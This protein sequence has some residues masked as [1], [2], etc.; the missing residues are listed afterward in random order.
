MGSA[1][2]QAAAAPNQDPPPKTFV[3]STPEAN[4]LASRLR[5]ERIA[6]QRT[7][8]HS[9]A[10]YDFKLDG[11]ACKIACPKTAA[12][13]SPWVWR[14]RFWGHQPQLDLALLEKGWHVGYCDVQDLL[15]AD[16]ALERWDAFYAFTQRLKLHSRPLLEG[17]SRG[18]LIVMRWASAHPERVCGIYV[19][20]GV[21]DIRSWPGGK[22]AS[23]G[24]PRV[25]QDA[26]KAYD[27]TEQQAAAFM[28]G[29]LDRLEPLAKAGVPILALINEADTVVPPAENG[30]LLVAR[31][32]E[33]GGRI[34][35][36]RRAGLGH[37][38]HS[39][40][41]PAPLVAFALES[42]ERADKSVTQNQTK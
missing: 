39:L 5:A 2:G 22:G 30:D 12:E 14:A 16:P 26:L 18:G 34:T 40:K 28:D 31:Y 4:E 11:V 23:Q 33:L 10:L 19:D 20:N 41:N 17:M 37:H 21:M 3:D 24:A 13:G 6:F 25:W 9:F 29:P 7:R 1:C 27:L 36:K 32:R 15:G 35:E 42:L 8:F 38:P